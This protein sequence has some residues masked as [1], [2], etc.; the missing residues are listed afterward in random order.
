VS[1]YT[2]TDGRISRKSWWLG[3]LG[4][5]V[6]SLVISLLVLPL[7]GVSMMPNFAAMVDG[8]ADSAA[9]ADS[10]AATARTAAWVNL[11]MFAI[12]AYPMYALGV[13]RRH[14]KDNNGMDVAVYLGLAVLL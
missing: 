1:L 10:I 13:K 8:S 4:L 11:V 2:T 7:V 14:D 6:V 12:F 5:V 9:I 3:V